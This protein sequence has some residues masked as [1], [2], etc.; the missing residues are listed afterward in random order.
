[1]GPG[2]ALWGP[3]TW[4][5]RRLSGPPAGSPP[6]PLVPAG[7]CLVRGALLCRH[8]QRHDRN[9]IFAAVLLTGLVGIGLTGDPCGLG[10]G[11]C[12]RLLPV[13]HFPAHVRPGTGQFPARFRP[14]PGPGGPPAD[15]RAD[16]QPDGQNGDD[17]RATSFAAGAAHFPT[18]GVI[19]QVKRPVGPLRLAPLRVMLIITRSPWT[20]GA[21]WELGFPLGW[22]GPTAGPAACPGAEWW[23]P[24]GPHCI[25]ILIEHSWAGLARDGAVLAQAQ[26]R[27]RERHAGPIADSG[28]KTVAA[29]AFAPWRSCGPLLIT[30]R[31]SIERQLFAVGNG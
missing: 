6:L 13:V 4:A 7:A 20:V 11:A 30:G 22:R 17:H 28:Q 5:P 27:G 14:G 19:P 24:Q 21:G 25:A 12:R 23:P 31:N 9:D 15:R 26:R 18:L 29:S 1:M 10:V 2:T 16:G 8:E 3:V